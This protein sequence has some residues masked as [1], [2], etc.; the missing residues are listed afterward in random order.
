VMIIDG[1]EPVYF[2]TRV[3]TVRWKSQRLGRACI[4]EDVSERRRAEK[5]AF[6]TSDESLLSNDNIPMI[7]VLRSQDEKIIEVNRSFILDLGYERKDV[8][9]QSLLQLGI[10]DIYQRGDFL[11]VLRSEGSVKNHSLSLVHSNRKK[12][13]YLVSAYKMDIV[14]DGYIVILASSTGEE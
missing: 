10:W 11:K 12:Q 4:L 14:E 2:D 6:G 9:G 7:F 8:V 13:S 5:S 3:S 1:R